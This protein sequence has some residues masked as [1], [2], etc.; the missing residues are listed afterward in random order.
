MEETLKIL[1]RT[2]LDPEEELERALYAPTADLASEMRKA[3][4]KVVR[5]AKVSSN[6]KGP[7]QRA[8]KAAASITLAGLEILRT[9]ADKT[10]EETRSEESRIMRAQIQKLEAAQEAMD[11][12]F[13]NLR[14][15]LEKA[16]AKVREEKAK[17]EN[18]TKQL[19]D[20]QHLIETLKILRKARE[21]REKHPTKTSRTADAV[22][23]ITTVDEPMEV[24]R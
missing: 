15:E 14:E 4:A 17:R 13:L 12:K 8:L 18:L 7:L 20:S 3:Q 22:E 2:K 1:K 24:E 6:L 11:S 10:A 16:Q 19:K 9:R 21:E 23:T 5:I